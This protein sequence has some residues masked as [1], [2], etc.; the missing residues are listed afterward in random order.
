MLAGTQSK[1]FW[2]EVWLENG[3][4]WS[5]AKATESFKKLHRE[6]DRSISAWLVES[7]IIDLY[8]DETIANEI[9]RVKKANATLWRP[10]PEVPHL[11]TAV[12]YWCKVD[13]SKRKELERVREQK[14]DWSALL[15]AD[16]AG[17]VAAYFASGMGVGDGAATA[18]QQARPSPDAAA[19]GKTG[20]AGATPEQAAQAER[21]RLAVAKAAD[22]DRKKQESKQKKDAETAKRKA[23]NDAFNASAA[24]KAKK[25]ATNVQLAYESS[26]MY[27][28]A[29]KKA[30]HMSAPMR[31]EWER[32][33]EKQCTLLKRCKTTLEQVWKQERED[34]E[35]VTAAAAVVEQFKK[36]RKG[37]DAH[38]KAALK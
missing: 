25:E 22:T 30:K 12:Q 28:A 4:K 19:E 32:Q 13:E 20:V 17:K 6:L 15:D 27:C 33:F 9:V 16:G 24:G 7:Q 36:H 5:R 21:D 11:A 14:I 34:M 23:D 26:L 1:K 37:F 38:S 10:H 31:H 3:R 18:V 8:K 35:P 2:Y 29:V